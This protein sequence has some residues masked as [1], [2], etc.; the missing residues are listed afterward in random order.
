M[1]TDDPIAYFI[2]WTVYGTY[3]QGDERFWTRRRQGEQIPQPRLMQW[4]QKRLKHPIVCLDEAQRLTV[5]E[6][7]GKH[8]ERR[9]WKLWAVNARAN[10][11]HV[12]VTSRGKSGKQVRDELKA[13]ATRALREEWDVFR[14]RPVWTTGG[15][16]KCINSE[17]DLETICIY[18]KVAQDRMDREK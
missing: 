11:V 14:E 5:N 8:C 15:D 9:H 18:V 6:V 12:V 13:N 3:L 7:C 16:W 4:H 2:T 10:H 1:A 17:D